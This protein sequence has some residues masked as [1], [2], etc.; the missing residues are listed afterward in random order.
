M[1]FPYTI[2]KDERRT[3]H[4]FA[5]GDFK[6]VK[7]VYVT[8][9]IAIGNHYH[10]NKDEVFFLATGKFLELQVGNT[11]LFNV[12]APYRIEVPKLTYHRF[13]CEKGSIL[14]GAAT[15]LHDDEDEIK[16]DKPIINE[17]H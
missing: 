13:V 6:Q 3:I 8:E 16:T 14:I 12:D 4:D 10:R 1:N 7:V 17:Y 15:E 9:E 5:S 11:L 2:N